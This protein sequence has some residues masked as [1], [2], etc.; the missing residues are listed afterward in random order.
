MDSLAPPDAE[1]TIWGGDD[2]NETQRPDLLADTSM[3]DDV[4]QALTI[5][6]H[7]TPIIERPLRVVGNAK[8]RA[9]LLLQTSST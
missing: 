8:A 5:A 3:V 2:K 4:E 1:R 6:R 9:Q 7:L